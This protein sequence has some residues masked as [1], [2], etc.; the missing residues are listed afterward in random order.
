MR[1]A[2]SLRLE[3]G[4]PPAI[5]FTSLTHALGAAVSLPLDVCLSL[6]DRLKELANSDGDR[7]L[8]SGI[9]QPEQDTIDK[10]RA[11]RRDDEQFASADFEDWV[12]ESIPVWE[13]RLEP[14][15]RGY[16]NI[17]V[18]ERLTSRQLQ[19]LFLFHHC[20]SMLIDALPSLEP[21][22]RAECESLIY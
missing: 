6:D 11:L 1:H 14:L 19:G 4:N 15:L 12:R 20:M 18:G 21:E 5:V 16:H 8:D 7:P 13:R 3:F 17:W 9:E 10:L 22:L 2:L